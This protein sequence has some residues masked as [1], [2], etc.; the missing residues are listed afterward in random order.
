VR[1]G[2]QLKVKCEPGH[3]CASSQRGTLALRSPSTSLEVMTLPQLPIGDASL[4]RVFEDPALSLAAK[5]LL[6]VVLTRPPGAR[7][8]QADLFATS[9]DPLTTIHKAARELAR[10]GL[11]GTFSGRAGNGVRLHRG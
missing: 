2:Q 8:S 4:R 11:V 9:S 10:T 6:A 1:G 5:G 7:V 3:R